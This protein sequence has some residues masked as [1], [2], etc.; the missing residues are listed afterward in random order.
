VRVLRVRIP[1]GQFVPVHTHRWPSVV[2]TLSA[3][4]FIRRDGDGNLLWDSRDPEAPPDPPSVLWLAPC[5]LTPSRTWAKPRSFCSPSSSRTRQLGIVSPAELHGHGGGAGC[6]GDGKPH[7][8]FPASSLP[9]IF[10]LKA[11]PLPGP[12]AKSDDRGNPP[13]A[14]KHLPQGGPDQTPA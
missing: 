4:D 11:K 14:P 3:G 7:N 9:A 8:L 1:P 6:G 5:R 12:D 10:F 13:A 2:Y